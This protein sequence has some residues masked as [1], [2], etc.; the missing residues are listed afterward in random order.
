M[1]ILKNKKLG[2]HTMKLKERKKSHFHFLQLHSMN[3]K[4]LNL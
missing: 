2:C 4:K 1:N 3:D